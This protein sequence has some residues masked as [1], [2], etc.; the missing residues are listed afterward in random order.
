MSH[1]IAPDYDVI[2]VGFG[3]SNLAL[4]IALEDC[5]RQQ[6]LS[7]RSLFVER[8][9]SFKWHGGM[10]LPGSNMQISFL[11]DLVSLRDPTSPFTFVNYLHKSG[12]LLDFSNCRTFYPS[13]IEFNDYLRWVADQF[14]AQVDYGETVTSVEPVSAGQSVVALRVLTRTAR[15]EEQ[16]RIARHLVVAVGGVP[17]VPAELHPI[18][19]DRRVVHTS[20]YLDSPLT[21][22]LRG[23][24]V[25]VAVIGGG[26][27]A[28]EVTLDL[29][30][31][32]PE[33]HID[34]VFRGHALKPSDSSPFVNEIFNPDYTDYF[35]SREA[36][37]RAAIIRS[38]RNTN[39]AVVDPELLDQ[40]YRKTYQQRVSGERTLA[41][42]PR[43]EI[44]SAEAGP[45]GITLE[46]LN[47]DEAVRHRA[48]YD[49]V[50]VATGYERSP[51]P[52]FLDPI[53]RYIEPGGLD[54]DYRLQTRPGF[55][56]QIHLQGCSESSHGLSDTLLS[57][58]PMRAQEITASL[59][60]T[61]AGPRAPEHDPHLA[62]AMYS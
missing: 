21:A 39:Y 45:D 4:A 50:I 12:R 62:E 29:S 9:P 5:A 17:H 10:L 11:K 7:C 46:L 13:R 59:V 52:A 42:H 33:A 40:L 49:A 56:P 19:G 25:R 14:S 48:A 30:D 22:E 20:A 41:L 3:P 53:R 43:S 2:G 6:R 35:H 54:R 24:P 32:L 36:A 8:Q 1:P 31:R 44:V 58:L 55:R 18:A 28:A 23:R 27:S 38:F 60:A 34:L 47:K 26:Q 37:Q 61:A 51:V 57:V 16:A 15:G